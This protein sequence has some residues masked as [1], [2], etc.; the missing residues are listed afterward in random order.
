MNIVQHKPKTV[1]FMNDFFNGAYGFAIWDACSIQKAYESNITPY[2]WTS[3]HLGTGTQV[4]IASHTA[5]EIPDTFRTRLDTEGTYLGID[6]PEFNPGSITYYQNSPL[7][8]IW[9]TDGSSYF[10]ENGNPVNFTSYP[11]TQYDSTTYDFNPMEEII[12][13]VQGN[14]GI[15]FPVGGAVKIYNLANSSYEIYLCSLHTANIIKHQ[16]DFPVFIVWCLSQKPVVTD[17]GTLVRDLEA[18]G[19]TV[20][21]IKT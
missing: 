6:V 18:N 11:A 1:T 15:T 2:D 20:Y 14:S 13:A 16:G 4:G 10:D 8:W 3:S 9:L 21:N 17:D 7:A 12:K 19:A 5:N